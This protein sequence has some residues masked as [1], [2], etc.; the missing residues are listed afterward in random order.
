MELVRDHTQCEVIVTGN[1]FGDLLSDLC[2]QL[3]GGMGI[4]PSANLNADNG[5][6]LF[7]PVNGSAPNLAGRGVVNPLGAILSAAM[8][9]SQLG[10]DAEAGVIEEAV[11][12]V[13]RARECTRDIGGELSTAEAGDA[14]EKHLKGS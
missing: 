8:M 3:I 1:L 5:K 2:A 10:F 11:V 4:A 6:G 13:V 7:G 9:L 14:V 12:A